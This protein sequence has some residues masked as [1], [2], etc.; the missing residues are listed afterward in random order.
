MTA[1]RKANPKQAFPPSLSLPLMIEVTAEG[2]SRR[3][4]LAVIPNP[5]RKAVVT[6][7]RAEAASVLP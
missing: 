1:R 2:S 5:W 4:H 3:R 6:G 7:G